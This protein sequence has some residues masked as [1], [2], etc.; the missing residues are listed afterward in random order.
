MIARAPVQI[1]VG[2][3][4]RGLGIGLPSAVGEGRIAVF[5]R[6]GAKVA[7]LGEQKVGYYLDVYSPVSRVV[8]DEY[9]VDFQGSVGWGAE[10]GRIQDGGGSGVDACWEGLGGGGVE[11]FQ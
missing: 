10:F 4:E 1:C 8:E 7:G 2:E 11:G 9:G 6:V 3:V 5:G